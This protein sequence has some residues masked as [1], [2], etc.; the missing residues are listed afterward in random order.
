MTAK[1]GEIKITSYYMPAKP[2]KRI[3][4][5]CGGSV[6]PKCESN[7]AKMSWLQKY[8]SLFNY[9]SLSKKWGNY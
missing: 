2:L 4:N 5:I 8:T 7:I 1:S 3:E 6:T 9:C